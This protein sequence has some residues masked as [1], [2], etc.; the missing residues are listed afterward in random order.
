MKR[1]PAGNRNSFMRKRTFILD[2]P[3][4][5]SY[6]RTVLSHGWC[7]LQPFFLD[8]PRRLLLRVLQLPSQPA[9][10]ELQEQ[11][12][13]R[14]RVRVSSP[15]PL[16][17]L[18]LKAAGAAVAH[19]LRLGESLAEFH[20]ELA[21]RDRRGRFAWVPRARAGRLLRAPSFFEDMVKMICT[22][23]CSWKATQRMVTGMVQKLG[24]RLDSD[25]CCFPTPEQLAGSTARF[26]SREVGCGYRSG[27][28][29]ELAQQV[30][31][32][33]LPS[34]DWAALT[35]EEAHRRL[36]ATKGIG[37]Y[38]AGNLLKLLGH[39]DHLS[40]DSWVRPKFAAVH[41]LKKVPD[42]SAIQRHYRRFGRWQG[43]VLWLDLTRDW[44]ED[45]D[46]RYP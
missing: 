45:A 6:W 25:Y 21:H 23:N 16:G 11:N 7:T 3:P 35:G 17:D 42:D 14:V 30:S 37:P 34:G 43:L 9:L 15:G 2:A 31:S 22:T 44:F 27:Y 24:T 5:F 19:I 29:I 10:A 40:L 13:G 39:Y 33:R 36:M 26:L 46:P 8:R 1:H 41:G 32:G 12:D 20:R 18:D 38:A 4:D 28:L